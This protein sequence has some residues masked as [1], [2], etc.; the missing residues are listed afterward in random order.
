MAEPLKHQFGPEIVALL[1]ERFATAHP[2]FD[3][4]RFSARLLAA[5]DDLELKARINLVADELAVSLPDDYPEAVGIV[6]SVAE[7]G[8]EGFAAW[9]L[10]SFV[11][12]HGLRHPQ[13]SLEMMTRL[14]RHW[15]CEFAVRPFLDDHLDLTRPFLRR[16]ARHDHEDVRRLASEGTRPRLPW[17]P[18]VQALLDEPEIGI[19]LLEVLRHDPSETVRRSVANHLNDIARDDPERVVEIARRWST[20][21]HDVD[22]RMIRHALRG[23]VKRGDPGALAVLGFTTDPAVRVD[24]FSVAPGSIPLGSQI[25]LAAT[26]TSTSD[27]DQR[28]V[29]DFVVHHVAANGTTSPK[30][31]K[32]TTASLPPAGT[33]TVAKRRR[34][35]TASTRRYH[36]GVH[37]VDLQIGGQPAATATFTLLDSSD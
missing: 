22:P 2:P 6:V 26:L 8:V 20:E 9:P 15:S 30:V 1:T 35:Q 32:W 14:T 36:A 21:S 23:L 29:V 5:F 11:E 31:F 7:S 33:I 19:E 12:R 24:D 34:I 37:R 17:G 28:L 25:E 13:L 10:C 27:E 16:W 18:K 4:D 3:A